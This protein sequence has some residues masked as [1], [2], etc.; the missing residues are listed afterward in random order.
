MFIKVKKK[1][2]IK[3]KKKNIH[4]APCTKKTVTE[5]QITPFHVIKEKKPL[6]RNLRLVIKYIHFIHNKLV[7]KYI[8][9]NNEK[10]FWYKY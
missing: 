1:T 3:K 6:H 10:I 8:E 7:F 4:S 9:I 2:S 5:E